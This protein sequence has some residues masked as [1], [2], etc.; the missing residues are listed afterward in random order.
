MT[1][2]VRSWPSLEIIIEWFVC[3]SFFF[4]KNLVSILKCFN[5]LTISS[6]A[7]SAPIA[8]Q[9][10][11]LNHCFENVAAVLVPPPPD[12]KIMSSTS[13]LEPKARQI[14][15]PVTKSFSS[16]KILNILD[17]K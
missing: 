2:I 1:K 14:A 6:P 5:S 12:E 7:T 8:P 13:I 11:V 4:T 10:A 16:F 9:K 15:E 17:F 3:F